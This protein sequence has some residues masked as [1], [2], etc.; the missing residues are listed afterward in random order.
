MCVIYETQ[1]ITYMI[2]LHASLLANALITI[3]LTNAMKCT[4]IYVT[5]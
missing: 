4:Y 2:K 5:M 1:Q 3:L